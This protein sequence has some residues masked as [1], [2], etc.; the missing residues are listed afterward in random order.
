[1]QLKDYIPNVDKK[2]SKA[3]FSG[4]KPDSNLSD[5][6]IIGD[7]LPKYYSYDLSTLASLK[8]IQLYIIHVTR[9]PLDVCSSYLRRQYNSSIG[10][11]YWKSNLAPSDIAN[12]WIKAWNFRSSPFLRSP[13]V[14]FLDLNYD[15]LLDR[16]CEFT[17]HLSK[18]LGIDNCF[19]T[20]MVSNATIPQ[21]ISMNE[22]VAIKPELSQLVYNW[23]RLP[24]L[25]SPGNSSNS[26]SENLILSNSDLARNKSLS[27][28]S[29]FPPHNTAPLKVPL[30]Q[31]PI[32]LQESDLLKKACKFVV[33]ECIEGDYYEFGVFRGEFFFSAVQTF[34]I[35]LQ[36]RLLA[37]NHLGVNKDADH[38][39]QQLFE[40]MRFHAFDSF[41]G[42]PPL[43]VEDS[44][45]KDFVEGQFSYSE[46]KFL[47]VG[48]S[49]GLAMN[50]IHTYP[51]WF[52]QTCAPEVIEKVTYTPAALIMLDCDLYS[53]AKD[54]FQLI[55]HLLQDGTILIIDDWFSNK[56]S[57][58]HGVQKAFYEWC[59]KDQISSKFVFTEYHKESWKRMSFIVN[60]T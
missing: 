11:D 8:G 57:P 56:G 17:R 10:K 3:F 54:A 44:Y 26:S 4:I 25:L 50:R 42:L 48:H 23:A 7:K 43:S 33:N 38:I 55:T 18:F 34:L 21:M 49:L 16:P 9:N 40:K 35:T 60:H 22:F 27:K 5:T 52:S 47:S 31:R 45:S 32:R 29:F 2:Y 37:S 15:Q 59:K 41:Q 51:G 19:E 46:E 1:M 12:E 30:K 36:R 6:E 53:S 13:T 28:S 14:N 58:Y 24:M 39:R 20:D